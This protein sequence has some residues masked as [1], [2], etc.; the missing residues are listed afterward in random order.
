MDSLT[1]AQSF[2]GKLDTKGKPKFLSNK[3]KNGMWEA[4]SKTLGSFMISRDSIAP[5]IAPL[6]FRNKQWLSNH[7]FLKLK[8]DDDYT[9]VKSYRG[10]INGQWILLEY[11]PKNK[12]LIYNLSDLTFDNVL[13]QLNVEVEDF[14]EN[15]TEYSIEFYRKK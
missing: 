11:E 2:I 15:K 14:V 13:H 3:I 12:T 4:S 5:K 6:N 7:N 8:I 9:G 10:E 1:S